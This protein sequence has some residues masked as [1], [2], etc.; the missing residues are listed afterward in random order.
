MIWLLFILG[1]II[2]LYAVYGFYVGYSSAAWPQTTGKVKHSSVVVK[3]NTAS[4]SKT[5][6]YHPSII[7]EYTVDSVIYNSRKIGNYIGFGNDKQFAEKIVNQYPEN[8]EIRVFYCPAFPRTS[9][10]IPGMKQGIEHCILLFTGIIIVLGSAPVL[11]S[12]DPNW[13]VDK[14]WAVIDFIT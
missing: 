3:T 12:D 11:F 4:S 2:S 9:V 7:Y 10:L 14:I 1:V 13:F 8:S 5:R 6:Y